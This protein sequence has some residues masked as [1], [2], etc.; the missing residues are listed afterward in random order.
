MTQSTIIYYILTTVSFIKMSFTP[1]K[2]LNGMYEYFL[3]NGLRVLLVPRPGID[4]CT[5]NITYHVGSAREGLGVTGATHFLEHLQFK[6]SK[7]FNGKEGMWKLEE[8]GMYM[9]ATTYLDRTNFFEVMQTKDLNDAIIREADRMFEPLLTE[10]SLKSEMTVVRNELERGANNS[11]QLLHQAIVG[12]AFQSHPYHHATIGYKDDVEHVSASALRK[13]H[14]TFYIPNNSTYT[15]VGNFD[16]IQVKDMVWNAFRNISAG[17]EPPKMYTQEEPQTGQRRIVIKQPSNT[18]LMGIAF[19]SVHGLHPDAI[20]LEVLAKLIGSGPSSPVEPL[21]KSGVIHDVMP[22]WERMKDPYI[23]SVWI[24]TNNAEYE[25]MQSAEKAMMKLLQNYPKPSQSE[26]DAAKAS[27]EYGWKEAMESTRGMASEIN[28]SISRGDPFDVYTRFDTLRNVTLDDVMRVAQDT[29]KVDTSTVGWYMPGKRHSEKT[30]VPLAVPKY[31]PAPPIEKLRAPASTSLKLNDVTQVTQLSAF[32]K[33]NSAKT[34]IRVSLQSP[35]STHNAFETMSR[36]ILANMMS[37]GFQ[38]KHKEFSEQ[39]IQSFLDTNGIERYIHNSPYGVDIT[40]SMPS[41]DPKIVGKM[42]ALLQNELTVPSLRKDTFEYLQKKIGAELYGSM[43]NV[44]NQATV[45][46]SQALFKDGGCNYL[47]SNEQLRAALY[48]L[49][50]ETI[51]D[52]HQS[53]LKRGIMKVS[54]LSP[55]EEII[56]HCKKLKNDNE[57]QQISNHVM[58]NDPESSSVVDFKIPGKTSCTVKWGHVIESPSIATKLAIGAL[59]NGFAGE[60][61]KVVRD[62]MGLTY[63]IYARQN[64]QHGAHVFEVTATFAPVNLQKGIAASERVMKEWKDGI[65]DEQIDIQKQMLIGSQVVS[66]DNPAVISATVHSCL[67]QD[68][69]VTSVDNFKKMVESVSYAAVRRALKTQLHPDRMK[70]VTVGTF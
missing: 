69:S 17:P 6:G 49:N 31:A 54:V 41:N 27:I 5:A 56:S 2:T 60:L 64:R 63:G 1:G 15:F 58:L 47:H 65:T 39:K 44:N 37:K 20:T 57:Y 11:F 55:S 68:K 16:P 8:K 23:F 53:L 28:E 3:P 7:K 42:V 35:A 45:L 61:M 62:K 32:T 19:K 10:A 46:L 48:D 25:T 22:S 12:Q 30:E 59:G 18:S 51:V 66:W 67:M 43:Q 52:E 9:N 50:H 70:R 26:L 21:R 14:D 24:T 13:F 36:E 40:V 33:Y 38:V 4:V 29:F 34:H